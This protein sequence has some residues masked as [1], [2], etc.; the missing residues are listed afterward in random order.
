MASLQAWQ[1]PEQPPEVRV[2]LGGHKA[3]PCRPRRV[4]LVEPR[5]LGRR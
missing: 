4:H 2:R 1:V 3:K 5:L